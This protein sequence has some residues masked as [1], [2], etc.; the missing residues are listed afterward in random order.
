MVGI[1]IQMKEHAAQVN[2]YRLFHD[3]EGI[4]SIDKGIPFLI[5]GGQ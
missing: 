1:F 3:L 4:N 5:E 2:I